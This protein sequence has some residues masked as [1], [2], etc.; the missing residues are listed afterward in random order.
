MKTASDIVDVAEIK[1]VGLRSTM[2]GGTV[3]EDKIR[4]KTESSDVDM[5][6]V[7][8]HGKEGIVK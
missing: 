1:H 7:E 8:A 5:V 2:M 4:K 6:E 3:M